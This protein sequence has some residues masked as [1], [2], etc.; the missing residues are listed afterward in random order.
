MRL[1]LIAAA[2]ATIMIAQPGRADFAAGDRAARSGD[3]KTAF[4]EWQPSADTGDAKSQYG[5]AWLYAEGRGVPQDRQ[6]A[7]LWCRRA[8]E[9]AVLW[10]LR[11]AQQ[12]DSDAQNNLGTAYAE[13][14]GIAQD[15]VEA[16]VWFSLAERQNNP[17]ARD[18]LMRL[19]AQMDQIQIDEARRKL[20][21]WL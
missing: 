20:G 17:V 14:E 19:K 2:L 11:A 7:A 15:L 16:F 9:L 12:G 13:G 6:K 10:Y 21:K 4:A 1:P 8:A 3:F 18:N 5:L